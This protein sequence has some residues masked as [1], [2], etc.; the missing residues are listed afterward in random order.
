[1]IT[2]PNTCTYPPAR[3]LQ[4]CCKVLEI[5]LVAGSMNS[6]VGAMEP[7]QQLVAQSLA[8]QMMFQALSFERSALSRRLAPLIM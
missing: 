8:Q 1:M 4:L 3:P 5:P 7:H 2:I 6:E